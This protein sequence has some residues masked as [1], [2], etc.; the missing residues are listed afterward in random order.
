MLHQ[1]VPRAVLPL[2]RRKGLEV[3]LSKDSSVIFFLLEAVKRLLLSHEQELII[4]TI[5]LSRNLIDLLSMNQ[6][7]WKICFFVDQVAAKGSKLS[8]RDDLAPWQQAD[9]GSLNM[10]VHKDVTRVTICL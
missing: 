5:T 10:L 6:F 4:K 7:K 3:Q 2:V 1:E 9:L 8:F